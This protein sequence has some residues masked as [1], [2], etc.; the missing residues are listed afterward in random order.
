MFKYN[1]QILNYNFIL[2]HILLNK[3]KN[4]KNSYLKLQIHIS[5]IYTQTFNINVWN[6]QIMIEQIL[7]GVGSMNL[8]EDEKFM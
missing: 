8:L 1:F 4:L 5:N 3:N 6:V 7:H 2:K